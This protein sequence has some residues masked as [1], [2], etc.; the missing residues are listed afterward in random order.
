MYQLNSI[1]RIGLLLLVSSV[2]F[3][4]ISLPLYPL[5]DTTEARYGEMARIMAETGDW[6]TPMFDYGIPFWGKPP[7]FT[8]LSAGGIQL[9]GNSE[10][11]IRLPHLL[12]GIITLSLVF[13][14]VR[15]LGQNRNN[16]FLATGI[17]ASTTAFIVISGAVMTDTVLTLGITLSM[18]SFWLSWQTA[19]KTWGY[20]F[21]VGAAMGLLAKGPLTLVLLGISITLWSIRRNRWRTLHRKLPWKNGLLL[22]LAI[23]LPWYLLAEWKTPGFLN[24]FIVGEHVMRFI[25]S[26]WN[27]DLYG[28]AHEEPRGTI[29]LFG[30]MAALPWTPLFLW[31]IY[32][33]WNQGE[34]SLEDESGYVHYLWCWMLSPLLL[35]TMAGNILLSYLMPSLPAF[36]L[37]L[38]HFQQRQQTASKV[39]LMGLLTPVLLLAGMAI[40]HQGWSSKISHNEILSVWKSQPEAQDLPLLYIGKRPFSAQY[41]SEGKAEK[42]TGKTVDIL[43]SQSSPSFVVMKQ[44]R[45]TSEVNDIPASCSTRDIIQKHVLL[46]CEGNRIMKNTAKTALYTFE[47]RR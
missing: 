42:T 28:T 18:V 45:F 25:D 4:L 14:F 38:T 1:G 24:Y 7:L 26:G 39:Y 37:L 17:L 12:V 46:F 9:L 35:F 44:N 41:Y 8:W 43:S 16:A 11:A 23:S 5:Y 32:R 19:S 40:M 34:D 15:K 33:Q 21:F 31:Q 29:W 47:K 13:I 10:L 2:I 22:M 36:A 27:G 3:R 6:I 20:L 30:L